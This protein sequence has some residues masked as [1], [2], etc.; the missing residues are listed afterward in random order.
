MHARLAVLI[1]IIS[2]IAWGLTWVP[3]KA[4]NDM[5]LNSLHMI[6][7]T[8]VTGSLV[9]SPW[10][11]RQYPSWRGKLKFMLMIAIAGGIANL[12]FQTAIYYGNVVRAMILFYLL[13]VWSVIGG[14]IFLHEKIDGLRLLAVVLCLSG[15]AMI[16]EIGVDIWQNISWL[17]VFAIA[18]GMG[19]A[20]TNIL[21]RF[22][23]E[24]PV[25]SKVGAMFSGC[26]V[27]ISI[28]IIIMAPSAAIPDNGAVPL[29]MLY[30]G[31]WLLLATLATQWGVTQMEAGRSSV[32]IVMELVTAILSAA[33][34]S[35]AELSLKEMTG[36]AMV[37][38]AVILEGMRSDAEN[39]VLLIQK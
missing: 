3:I 10:L 9:S 4:L 30:G 28:S 11:V 15:A 13:P 22:T 2:S 33:L 1:L 12:A 23:P 5:G 20:A 14:R 29:A 7:I 38:T 26:A 37:I 31:V 21:F 27:L 25:M 19:L 35:S 18:S 32:I 16:L 39:E 17:D 24:I 34:L 36:A 6:L 8:F